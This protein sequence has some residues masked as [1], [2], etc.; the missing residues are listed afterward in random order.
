[1]YIPGAPGIG[2]PPPLPLRLGS[3]FFKDDFLVEVRGGRGRGRLLP[4][5]SHMETSIKSV[6]VSVYLLYSAEKVFHILLLTF[7]FGIVIPF[8][9]AKHL[10]NNEPVS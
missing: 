7:L 9:L 5:P 8:S 1:M 2:D 6:V 10:S 3:A 4:I